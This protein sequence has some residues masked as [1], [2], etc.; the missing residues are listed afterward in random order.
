MLGTQRDQQ[1]VPYSLNV[2]SLARTRRGE[3]PEEQHILGLDSGDW[4]SFFYDRTTSFAPRALRLRF[5]N[6]LGPQPV[7]PGG[8]AEGASVCQLLMATCRGTLGKQC[9]ACR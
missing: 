2:L 3:A 8:G 5:L 6:A 4:L 9:G 1:R 7:Q